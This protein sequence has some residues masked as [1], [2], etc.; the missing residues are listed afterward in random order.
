MD[1]NRKRQKQRE[2]AGHTRG[3][4]A[5][6]SGIRG[7]RRG[8]PRANRPRRDP[9]KE[10]LWRQRLDEEKRSGLSIRAYCSRYG[11]S[12]PQ[13]YQWRGEIARR[14]A[15]VRAGGDGGLG[16]KGKGKEKGRKFANKREDL[17]AGGRHEDLSASDKREVLPVGD[18][19]EHK[20]TGRKGARSRGIALRPPAEVSRSRAGVHCPRPAFIELRPTDTPA[21]TPLSSRAPE[22]FSSVSVRSSG[23]HSS[24]PNAPGAF[25]LSSQATAALRPPLAEPCI[26]I[27]LRNGRALRVRRGFDPD[28]LLELASVLESEAPC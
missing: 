24:S 9:E 8:L 10:R 11:L 12:E 1:D 15:E 28:L 18:R 6:G 5:G 27:V 3:S 25:E 16:R 19:R 7:E 23:R 20:R 26:E 17:S 22:D 21:V 13:F 14:D 4:K 2:I